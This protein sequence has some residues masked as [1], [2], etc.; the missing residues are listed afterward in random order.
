M[1]GPVSVTV[2]T[3]LECCVPDFTGKNATLAKILHQVKQELGDLAR[4]EVVPSASRAERLIYYKRMIAAL[5]NGG[6]ELPF[7]KNAGEWAALSSELDV[8]NARLSRDPAIMERLGGIGSYLF[9][10]PPIIEIDGKAVFVG[11]VPSAV[12]LCEAIRKSYQLK[13]AERHEIS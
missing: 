6:Y 12:Q 11:E 5:L 8:A 7:V 3:R 10:I 13:E 2:F 1:A 9:W 4:I